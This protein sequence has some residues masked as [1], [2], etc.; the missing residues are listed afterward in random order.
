MILS[1]SLLV[2]MADA[3]IPVVPNDGTTIATAT[4]IIEPWKS[5]FYY[6]ALEP[7]VP[8]Y[9]SFEATAGER[10]RFMLNVPIPGGTEDSV[11]T[12]Y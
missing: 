1:L 11:P 9:Y 7:D 5:W 4:E 8:H 2:A 6:S 10:I 12:W 3:H